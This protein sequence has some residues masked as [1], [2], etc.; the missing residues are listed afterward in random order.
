MTKVSTNS[1][2]KGAQKHQNTFAFHANKNSKKTKII[3]SLP[4]NGV[5]VEHIFSLVA[6]I[7]QTNEIITITALCEQRCQKCKDIIDW[8]KKFKKYK[9]LTTPKRC[10]GC[11]EKTVKEAYHILCN[12]CTSEKGVCAKCQE[13]AQI[14]PSGT[15]SDKELLQEQQEL[16]R[17]LSTL[18]ERR[19]RSYLRRLERG[20]APPLSS[21]VKEGNKEDDID[22]EEEDD[23]DFNDEENDSEDD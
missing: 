5:Y 13:V 19:R 14:T 9:P 23:E 7:I 21:L 2:K 12:K 22:E 3:N 6:L 8:R 11:E 10:V 15:K 16:E 1:K 4:I 17:I 18:P 20:E